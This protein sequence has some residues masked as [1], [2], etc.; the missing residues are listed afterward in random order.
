[1]HSGSKR[2]AGIN[3]QNHLVLILRLHLFPGRNNQYIVNREL[4][5]I[6]LPVV[7]PV[8]ILRFFNRDCAFSDIQIE[9]L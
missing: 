3:M 2:C 9:F 1:M 4:M 5:K 7:D 6:L 8:D